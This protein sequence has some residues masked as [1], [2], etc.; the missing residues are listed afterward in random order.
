MPASRARA[1][2]AICWSAR[3]T[4]QLFL[5]LRPH[6]VE[7]AASTAGFLSTTLMMWKPN[8]LLTRSLTC[9]ASRENAAASNS[10]TMRP[11]PK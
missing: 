11:R 5:D 9:P 7:R 3:W 8:W 2:R 4:F 10:G 6:F 1:P